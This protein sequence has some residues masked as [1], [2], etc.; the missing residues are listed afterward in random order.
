MLL[1]LHQAREAGRKGWVDGDECKYILNL[2]RYRRQLDKRHCL[3]L[4]FY[5]GLKAQT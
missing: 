4:E 5:R 2:T 1:T 3:F